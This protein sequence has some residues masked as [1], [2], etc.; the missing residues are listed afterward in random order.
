MKRS[1]LAVLF[2]V[3]FIDLVGFGIV[4]PLLPRY[5][6]LYGVSDLEQ[7]VLMAS[8]S[9]MQ[10]LFAPM[11]GR[12]SDRIGRRPVLM[13]GLAG[14]VV[15]YTAFGLA[16]SYAVLLGSRIAAGI[17]GATIG[18][19]AAYIADVT[20]QEERGKGMALIGAAFGIGFT[21]GPVIG[22]LT[23]EG[24]GGLPGFIAA[25][26]SVGALVMAAFRLPEPERHRERKE[27][28]LSDSEG[29]G[30]SSRRRPSRSS[31][32]SRRG[33]RSSSRCSKRRCP[34][35]P[36]CGSRS[37]SGRTAGSSGSWDSASC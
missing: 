17:F 3:V 14:S 28:G 35:S 25:G 7:G 8:F 37:T 19:A 31:S 27:G 30:T 26:L 36:T 22:A 21:V 18:T 33:P 13:I 24:H 12:L 9:A 1:P 11:W 2:L 16:G 20:T 34:A 10:F 6:K 32:G 15:A 4:L 29:S 5:A 23:A